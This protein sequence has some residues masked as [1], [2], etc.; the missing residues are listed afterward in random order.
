MNRK[1]SVII[2]IAVFL[3]VYL[4]IG[5]PWVVGLA[6]THGTNTAFLVFLAFY[7]I[8]A[9]LAGAVVGRG[10]KALAMF[11]TT[12]MIADI[13]LFPMMIPYSGPPSGLTPEQQISSDMFFYSIYTGAGFPH[14]LA[15]W[16]TYLFTPLAFLVL[17]VYELKASIISRHIPR[18]ML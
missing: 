8:F 13:W 14:V 10:P 12:F 9:Y 6:R 18:V 16:A 1:L 5:V 17:F 7:C 11:I 4:S 3:V 15:W 2:A